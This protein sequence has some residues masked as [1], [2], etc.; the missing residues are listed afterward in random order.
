MDKYYEI[1]KVFSDVYFSK[2]KSYI[3]EYSK[4]RRKEINKLLGFISCSV[5][6]LALVIGC[7]IL[8][9]NNVV[10]ND[11]DK[12]AKQTFTWACWFGGLILFCIFAMASI[13]LEQILFNLHI[14]NPDYDYKREVFKVVTE[15]LKPH[16]DLSWS[17]PTLEYGYGN[18]FFD[19]I[20]GHKILKI[21]SK[22]FKSDDAFIGS[23]Q[24]VKYQI[25]EVINRYGSHLFSKVGIINALAFLG[26]VIFALIFVSMLFSFADVVFSVSNIVLSNLLYTL[27]TLCL[28]L[29]VIVA[30]GRIFFSDNGL[31]FGNSSKMG[32]LDKFK[33]L[34][35]RFELNKQ[36]EGHTIILENNEE[37]L[38]LKFFA[39]NNFEKV[40]LEDVE[41]SKK[42]SVYSTNQI[43][44][45]YML[46]SAMMERLLNL[47]QTFKSKYIRASFVGDELVLAIQ[48]DKD[49][50]RLAGFWT[51][52]NSKVYQTMFL[53]L[54]S[55]LKITDALNLQSNTGL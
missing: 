11:S 21:N 49:L 2:I 1:Q 53:E 26:I 9:Y 25:Y 22:A 6:I 24:N 50:F 34:I 41:F 15:Q 27:T 16:V 55:I 44:A 38:F 33:G 29:G 42:F 17:K 36:T 39:D 47:K 31:F 18:D 54:I 4:K 14:Y 46:T 20:N 10:V 23:F 28:I 45:R 5:L 7:Y 48:S 19:L 52:T 3:E 43:E 12:Y 32:F 30:V 13:Y 8:Y 51:E 35:V 37:N 40:E